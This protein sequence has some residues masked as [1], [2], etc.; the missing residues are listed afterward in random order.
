[1]PIRPPEAPDLAVLDNG[2]LGEALVHV[3]P[4]RPH[5]A[6]LGA[7]T[8][9]GRPGNTTPADPRSRRNRTSRT[10]RPDGSTGSNAH[11]THGLPTAC[12][13]HGPAS[14]ADSFA[15]RDRSPVHSRWFSKLKH[16]CI[17]REEFETLDEARAAISDYVDRYHHR[18][19]SRL[20]YRTPR[21]VAQTWKDPED[22][23]IRAA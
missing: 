11:K 10:G 18:P 19:H 6:S 2:H 3:D 16:R 7:S 12:A 1:M 4:D 20:A 5:P 8:T 15:G 9:T 17:W 23:S 13:P 14:G 22:Q 21:E